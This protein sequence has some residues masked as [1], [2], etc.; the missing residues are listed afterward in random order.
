[1]FIEGTQ[2]AK[3]RPSETYNRTVKHIY[4]SATKT[5]GYSWIKAISITVNDTKTYLKVEKSV[6]FIVLGDLANGEL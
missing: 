4:I 3:M 2:L 6:A 5:S 1:M